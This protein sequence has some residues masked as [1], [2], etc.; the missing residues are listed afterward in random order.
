MKLKIGLMLLAMLSLIACAQNGPV[1]DT[2]CL[3]AK[4]IFFDPADRLTRKTEND[5]IKHN[6]KGAELCGWKPPS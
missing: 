1:S 5:I 4:P 6:E 2:F 3:N